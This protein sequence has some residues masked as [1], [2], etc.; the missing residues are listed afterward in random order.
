MI[1]QNIDL[2]KITA[3]LE[4]IG[5]EAITRLQ[6]RRGFIDIRIINGLIP[7]GLDF[8]PEVFFQITMFD[9]ENTVSA[10]WNCPIDNF[11]IDE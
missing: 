1:H 6:F 8:L 5:F 7:K 9:T 11:R 4:T 10:V 3:S 2:D